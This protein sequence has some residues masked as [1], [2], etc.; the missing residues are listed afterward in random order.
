M[1]KEIDQLKQNKFHHDK[2]ITALRSKNSSDSILEQLRNGIQVERVDTAFPDA[3][4]P[5]T[6]SKKQWTKEGWTSISSDYVWIDHLMGLYF[7]WEYPIFAPLSKDHFLE[8]YKSGN[9]RYCSSLLVNAI[10]AVG[11]RYSLQPKAKGI[12]RDSMTASDFFFAEAI[13]LLDEEKNRYSYTTIQSLGLMSIRQSSCDHLEESLFYSGQSIRLAVE[14]G[15]HNY[16][17][18]GQKSEAECIVRSATFWGAFSLDGAWSLSLERLP[19]FSENIKKLKKPDR[20]EHADTSWVPCTEENDLPCEIK[21]KQ[22]SNIKSVFLTFCGLSELVHNS[23]YLLYSPATEVTK[24]KLLACYNS[25]LYWYDK[26]PVNLQHGQDFTPAVLFLHI[27]YHFAILLLFRPFINHKIFLSSVS[28]REVCMQAAEAIATLISSYSRL[29]TLSRSPT[30]LPYC[31]LTST[32]TSVII[33][34]SSEASFNLINKGIA[35]QKEITSHSFPDRALDIL[36]Y[37]SELL[38][39]DLV[40]NHD[41]CEDNLETYDEKENAKF[42]KGPDQFYSSYLDQKTPHTAKRELTMQDKSSLLDQ[43]PLFWSFPQ[44][45]RQLLR[46][47]TDEH[48]KNLGFVEIKDLI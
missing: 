11:C 17:K 23:L 21:P 24:T 34:G 20:F 19:H 25:Y 16:T 40:D 29:Y 15:L 44:R 3:T 12:L 41:K 48:M 43:N 14:M 37:S 32:V 47:S 39:L 42:W 2:L 45:N 8:D 30:F 6:A 27:Y 18:P 7:S 31:T 46:G 28:P 9:E 26:I 13:R 36:H 4:Q 35:D 22:V 10:L 1:R 38:N 33:L 5:D